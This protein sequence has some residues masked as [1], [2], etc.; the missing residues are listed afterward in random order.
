MYT[1]LGL[2][3]LRGNHGLYVAVRSLATGMPQQGAR[4]QLVAS[5][6]R[7]L[8]EGAVGG[9]GLVRFDPGLA[10]GVLGNR[11]HG[12]FAFST[13]GDFSTLPAIY[14]ISAIAVSQAEQRRGPSTRSSG[15]TAGSIARVKPSMPWSWYATTA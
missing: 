5:A 14:S 7:V 9:D 10:R 12:V 11:L 15:P 8:A 13:S 2:Q 3:L 6:N 4:M 1:D